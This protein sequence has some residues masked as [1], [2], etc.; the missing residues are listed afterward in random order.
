MLKLSS[1]K[2][3]DLT[4]G[5]FVKS[6]YEVCVTNYSESYDIG[7]QLSLNVQGT[8]RKVIDSVLIQG[9]GRVKDSF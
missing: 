9:W 3:F 4:F 8:P 7:Q 5:L 6:L 2:T 1:A